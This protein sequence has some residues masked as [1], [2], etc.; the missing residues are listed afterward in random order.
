MAKVAIALGSNLG[1]RLGHLRAGLDGLAEFGTISSV[2]RVHETD[3]V[4][5][6][7]QGRYLNAVVVI[8]TDLAPLDV[9]SALLEIERNRGRERTVRWGPRTLDLDLIV[10][11]GQRV[12]LPTLEV[13]HPRAHERGF[14]L[15][16]LAEV[17]PEARLANGSTARE[18]LGAV[19]TSGIRPWH[20]SWPEETPHLG[21]EAARWVW[22]QL[23]LFAVWLAIVIAST[24][25]ITTARA[26]VGT[27]VLVAGI[28]A[29]EASRRA[30]GRNLTPFPQPRAGT[31][32]VNRGIYGRVRHPIYTG[33]V[34]SLVGASVLAGSIAGV[35]VAAV[36]LIFFNAKASVEERALTIAVPEYAGYLDT[37]E[38]RFLPW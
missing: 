14:V 19:G 28:A 23:V 22:A 26:I 17:W 37:V 4:G 5:G 32:L 13:P 15:A 9:L 3:P 18:A 33:V 1:D 12:D 29:M 6:P 38:R 21:A 30:L 11:E 16:P 10:Y 8:E 34:T 20:G 35:V 31:T 2:S 24:E 27:L 25:P 36:V 7:E